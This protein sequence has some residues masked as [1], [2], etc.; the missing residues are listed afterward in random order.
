MCKSNVMNVTDIHKYYDFISVI[1]RF[2]DLKV[3]V[4]INTPESKEEGAYA[5]TTAQYGYHLG[6]PVS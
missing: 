4:H 3:A 5:G 6:I 2:F 1:L